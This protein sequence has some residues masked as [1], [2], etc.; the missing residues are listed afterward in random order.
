MKAYRSE[1]ASCLL[2]HREL[3]DSALAT[4][5]RLQKGNPSSCYFTAF[6]KLGHAA[7]KSFMAG[8][9]IDCIIRALRDILEEEDGTGLLHSFQGRHGKR[10]VLVTPRATCRILSFS[11]G[12]TTDSFR[13][14]NTK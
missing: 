2:G 8:V 7:H 11:T 1:C 4:P 3:L 12:T 10:L 9:S 14:H 5:E 6:C 13:L